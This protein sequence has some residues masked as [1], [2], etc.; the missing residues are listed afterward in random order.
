M[1]SICQHC[2][3]TFTA[4]IGAKPQRYCSAS[5]R[6]AVQNLR[7]RAGERHTQEPEATLKPSNVL[8]P[9]WTRYGASQLSPEAVLDVEWLD[10]FHD[11]HR[12]VA[13]RLNKTKAGESIH[14]EDAA[15]N[16][17]QPL[18]HA[19]MLGG[20]WVGRVRRKGAVV[21]ASPRFGS[22][23]EAKI[24]VERHLAGLPELVAESLALA[25]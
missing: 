3:S 23:A 5:C 13:G 16:D 17:R 21:W 20:E 15:G 18:G 25:A 7:A 2:K 22:V 8:R 11:L 12:C 24:A 1:Q 19:V 9:V 4:R 10:V 14:R 6:R